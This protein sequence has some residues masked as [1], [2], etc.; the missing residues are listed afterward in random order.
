MKS[1]PCNLGLVLW[2]RVLKGWEAASV[3]VSPLCETPGCSLPTGPAVTLKSKLQE[4][5]RLDPRSHL[6]DSTSLL[7][8][9]V[10]V[11]AVV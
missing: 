11:V 9:L 3:H 2:E 10:S 1:S 4:T 5:N 8:F 7:P 6:V